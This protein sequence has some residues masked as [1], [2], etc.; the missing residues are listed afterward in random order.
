MFRRTLFSEKH[1]HNLASGILHSRQLKKISAA[2]ISF[3][4][5]TLIVVLWE[6]RNFNRKENLPWTPFKINSILSL[7]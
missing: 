2:G 3:L 1:F 5:E 6:N 4:S 7:K